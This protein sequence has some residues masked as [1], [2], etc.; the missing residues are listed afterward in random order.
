MD[1]LKTLVQI[2]AFV[3]AVYVVL[4]ALL[5]FFQEK[6]IFYP[7]KLDVDYRYSFTG[8]FEEM[9]LKAEDGARLNA[10]LFK[11]EN[12]KGLIFYL[13]GNAGNLS[14]W[15]WAAGFYTD[16]G[17]DVFM[18]DYR[19]YGKS[20]GRISS[21]YQLFR[22]IQTAYDE[23]KKRYNEN[24]IIV[25]GYSLGSAP[26][27]KIAADNDPA[28][29]ILQAPFYSMTDLMKEHYPF[30][31]VFLLKY[32][33]PV[34]EFLKHYENRIVVFYGLEDEVVPYP[35]AMKLKNEFGPRLQ[36]ITLE[37]QGHNGMTDNPEYRRKL[38]G[39]LS[40]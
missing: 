21:Q 25:L 13:H 33:F 5:Y 2:S 38:S 12:P 36:L 31:P 18:M 32:K 16:L 23:M 15:G 39:I 37:G 30:V 26:A 11:A 34:H 10:L 24:E 40:N 1:M 3:F 20:G 6:F 8:E 19:G 14:S 7:Q 28:L 22:D 29:L 27:S 35:S 4:C 9:S 17:Y